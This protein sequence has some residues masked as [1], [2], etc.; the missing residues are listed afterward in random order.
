MIQCYY[1]ITPVPA[2]PMYW[3]LIFAI[4]PAPIT[5]FADVLAVPGCSSLSNPKP[6]EIPFPVT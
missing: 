4:P 6:Q 1:E 3:E 2:N 5:E